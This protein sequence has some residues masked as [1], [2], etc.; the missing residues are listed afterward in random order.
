MMAIYWLYQRD[1]EFMVALKIDDTMHYYTE[2]ESLNK[3]L[4]SVKW[5]ITYGSIT[6]L[7]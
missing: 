6:D 3:A 2:I 1:N 7:A 5:L 4:E